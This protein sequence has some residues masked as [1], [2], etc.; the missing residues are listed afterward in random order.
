MTG[1]TGGDGVTECPDMLE[2]CGTN[3]NEGQ[4]LGRKCRVKYGT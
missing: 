2:Q 3:G 1:V 4:N